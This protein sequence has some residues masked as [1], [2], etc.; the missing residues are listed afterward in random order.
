MNKR[1]KSGQYNHG[2]CGLPTGLYDT[3]GVELFTGDIVA[4]GSLHNWNENCFFGF[5]GLCVVVSDCE[6]EHQS[7]NSCFVMGIKSE[8]HSFIDGE[9]ASSG[10]P[11]AD[12]T[13][14]SVTQNHEQWVLQKVK[15]WQDVVHME[16]VDHIT[17]Y[18]EAD[19]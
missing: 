11:D 2:L 14:S 17:F 7:D 9:P 4:I 6:M 18:E 16:K 10:H 13:F 5:Q 15:G 1:I 19:Q 8:H 12:Y 3:A